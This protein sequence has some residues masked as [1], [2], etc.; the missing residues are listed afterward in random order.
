MNKINGQGRA[1]CPA[2]EERL[3][4]RAGGTGTLSR[5]VEGPGMGI[6]LQTS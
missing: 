6:S 3:S 5:R 1:E 4:R 2:R